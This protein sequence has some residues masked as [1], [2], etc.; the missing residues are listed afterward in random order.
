MQH[1]VLI[2]TTNLHSPLATKGLKI[3]EHLE[4][5][6]KYGKG[7]PKLLSHTRYDT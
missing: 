5:E 7:G 1:T 3:R 2:P 4:D 6:S